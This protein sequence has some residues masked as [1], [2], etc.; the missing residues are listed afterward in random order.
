MTCKLLSFGLFFNNSCH[1]Y[2]LRQPRF[3]FINLFDFIF[4]CAPFFC[5]YIQTFVSTYKHSLPRAHAAGAGGWLPLARCVTVF[6]LS[7]TTR[8]SRIL[9]PAG[10]S[11]TRPTTTNAPPFPLPH[12]VNSFPALGKYQAPSSARLSDP[13]IPPPSARNPGLFL[14]SVGGW[15]VFLRVK[16][17]QGKMLRHLQRTECEI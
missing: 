5:S 14:G 11:A 6:R 8:W 1:S 17:H 15:G 12:M 9:P 3:D 2:G 4:C 16:Q 13:A 10:P 7:S